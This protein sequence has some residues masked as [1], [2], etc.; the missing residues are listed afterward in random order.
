MGPRQRSRRSKQH[1]APS[2]CHEAGQ[3]LNR[4]VAV[5]AVADDRDGHCPRVRRTLPVGTELRIAKLLGD[6]FA[7][8]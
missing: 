2:S 3:L 6:Q 1:P 5:V 8:R 7:I 4:E